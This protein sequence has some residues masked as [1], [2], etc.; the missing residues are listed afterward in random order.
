M[1]PIEFTQQMKIL[2]L[3][4]NKDFDAETIEVWYKYFKDI[5]KE[6]FEKALNK[7]ITNNKYM[8][9]IAEIIEKCKEEQKNT[10]YE[11]LEIMKNDNYFKDVKEYEK[12]LVWLETKIIPQWFK[13]DMKKYYTNM[14]EMNNKLIEG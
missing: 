2:A 13:E 5:K 4:Y 6:T 7:I 11:I 3:S 12:A 1:K 14:I 8:P 9:S 10:T